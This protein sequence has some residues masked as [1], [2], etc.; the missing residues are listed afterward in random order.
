MTGMLDS[1]TL[2]VEK[3]GS[4]EILLAPERPTGHAGN[5]IATKQVRTRRGEGGTTTY[6]ARY[7]SGRQLFCDWERED[8]VELEIA[9]VDMQGAHPPALTPE[10]VAARLRRLGA[11]ARGQMHFWN[12]FYTDVLET[13]GDR[14]GDG[15]VFMPRNAFN[16]PNAL[17]LAT[18]GGQSTNIYAGGIYE[19]APD[20]AMIVET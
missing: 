5:F 15:K 14:N 10:D 16:P 17:G 11:L 12:A 7:L 8:A 13:Y 4:F 3:D 9:R 6:V 20:E 2:Q 18:G 1:T 19:L